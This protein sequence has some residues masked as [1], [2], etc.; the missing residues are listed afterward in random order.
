[1]KK[2]F[3]INDEFIENRII[4]LKGNLETADVIKTIV[5]LHKLDEKVDEIKLYISCSF[6]NE[7]DALML[8]D[9]IKNLKSSVTTYALGLIYHTTLFVLL[10]GEKRV[11]LEHT[12]CLVDIYD[13]VAYSNLNNLKGFLAYRNKVFV[14]YTN[15]FKEDTNNNIANLFKKKIF[16]NKKKMLS[17]NILTE[18]KEGIK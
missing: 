18:I 15:T 10:A 12:K 14:N 16:L 8:H 17:H 1:M 5:D 2:E 4:Y 6:K 13:P 11:G 9:I 3:N 7:T